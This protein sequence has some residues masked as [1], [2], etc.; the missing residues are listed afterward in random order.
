[1]ADDYSRWYP[2]GCKGCRWLYDSG[3]RWLMRSPDCPV[4]GARLAAGRATLRERDGGVSET[5]S[6]VAAYVEKLRS[7][8]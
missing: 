4:H 2:D 1:M 7:D 3:W 8:G 6:I 5:A